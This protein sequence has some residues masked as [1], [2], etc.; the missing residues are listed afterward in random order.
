M[1]P[2]R[3]WTVTRFCRGRHAWCLH[4][5]LVE[6]S[7]FLVTHSLL[8]GT[9][10]GDLERTGRASSPHCG[11]D[12]GADACSGAPG[13]GDTARSGRWCATPATSC[14]RRGVLR[15]LLRDQGLILP[16]QLPAGTPQTGAAL[17]G[18]VRDHTG[19]TRRLAGC[20][21][22]LEQVR[23]PVPFGGQS[24]GSRHTGS[25]GS[26]LRGCAEM[27][28]GATTYPLTSVRPGRAG[29]PS[30]S[31]ELPAMM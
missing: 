3:L 10:G 13:M 29:Q 7:A 2:S 19:G 20:R 26:H 6:S 23:P 15:G 30:G 4:Q 31:L 9:R 1:Q 17:K 8:L 27:P 11:A 22:L 28:L 24:R 25:C 18:R 5:R 16:A 12:P 14:P 21:G